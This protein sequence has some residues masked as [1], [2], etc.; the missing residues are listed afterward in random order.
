MLFDSLQSV[1]ILIEGVFGEMPHFIVE[2]MPDIM[3]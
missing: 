2:E 3:L 1:Y